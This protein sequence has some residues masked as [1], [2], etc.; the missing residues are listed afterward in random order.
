MSEI[1]KQGIDVRPDPWSSLRLITDKPIFN[2]PYVSNIIELKETFFP[3][4][5]S[6]TIDHLRL[7]DIKDI[8]AKIWDNV[9]FH[10]KAIVDRFLKKSKFNKTGKIIY[11]EAKPASNRP[12]PEVRLGIILE[13]KDP[14]SLGII[15]KTS[16]EFNNKRLENKSPRKANS[17]ANRVK[18]TIPRIIKT[19]TCPLFFIFLKKQNQTYKCFC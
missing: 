13:E 8:N 10:R 1:R 7:Y 18:T 12:E 11:L 2:K 3:K 14:R 15:S 16:N 19:V 5:I 9:P 6:E 17:K 4:T